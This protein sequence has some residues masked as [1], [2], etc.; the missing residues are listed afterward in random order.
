[1]RALGLGVVAYLLAAPF[2]A[3]GHQLLILAIAWTLNA[4]AYTAGAS[5]LPRLLPLDPIYT[6]AALLTIGSI[7]PRGLAVAAPI[8]GMLDRLLPVL[9]EPAS[10]VAPGAWASAVV[11]PGV[12]VIS[13]WASLLLADAVLVL[14]AAF[15]I[16]RG[17]NGRLWLAVL[18]AVL[19]GHHALTAVVISPPDLRD[20]EAAGIPF[21]IAMLVSGDVQ[22]G[23]RLAERLAEMSPA[24][25]APLLG[26]GLLLATY[27]LA[28]GLWLLT[29]LLLAIVRAYQKR[30][31]R[32][33]RAVIEM[34]AA[35]VM[36]DGSI[37][38][39]SGG[40]AV[41]L[42]ERAA[43]VMTGGSAS[44]VS[45]AAMR[46]GVPRRVLAARLGVV[47]L[48]ALV[49]VTPLDDLMAARAHFLSAQPGGVGGAGGSAERD[50]DERSQLVAAA[51]A[52]IQI[53]AVVPSAGPSVVSVHG[54]RFHYTYLVN[55]IP[56]T[57]KGI[58]YNVRYRSLS[59]EAR[60]RR[61]DHDF[62]ILKRS[63]VN[64]IFGWEPREFDRVL[65]DAAA[66]H[67]LGVA[68]PFELDPDADY[69]DPLV[70][71]RLT[72][73]V[74][75]WVR[76]YKDHPAIRMWAIGNE[77]LHKLV[78]PSWM[79]LQSRP[80]WERQAVAFTRFYVQLVDRV[81]L[82]DPNHPIVHRDAEDAYI[83]WLRDGFNDGV[84]RPWFIYGINAYTPRLAQ[85]LTDWP[86]H[87]FDVAL[88]ISEFA[89][90]GVSPVDR[91]RGYSAMWRVIEAAHGRTLG[92]AIYAWTTAG[93]EEVDRVF[94]LVD[95]KG[96]PVDGS[97]AAV[98][99]MYLGLPD[100]PRDD[101]ETV[102]TSNTRVH[103]E[104]L[105]VIEL[106]Q[107]DRLYEIMSVDD[108][109]SVMGNLKDVPKR[110]VQDGELE[111]VRV[112]DSQ[113]R[114]W[115]KTIGIVDEWWV[116]WKPSTQAHRKLSFLMREY[117]SG[118]LRAS[119]VYQGPR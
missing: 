39:M 60:I 44:G 103:D 22:G 55:G 29:R 93:P 34:S 61:L 77:V 90:G 74:L 57:I 48:A 70:R 25:R 46:A 50:A 95:A 36:T 101:V 41:L 58:G 24:V 94:G 42:P 18:G 38:L 75:D 21:A 112:T 69:G 98:Q 5:G 15:L 84:P 110:A 11:D 100:A 72:S 28:A 89:P 106:I 114:A 73:D 2:V 113:R 117:T 8:G 3:I 62:A 33:L 71:Q 115:Q 86:A 66:R 45:S 14:V 30:R 32:S 4:V 49:V 16:R 97:F 27:A 104:A 47:G 19:L 118:T 107:Q 80:E 53:D 6:S 35:P 7:Q 13:R 10:L 83:S 96:Q 105:R 76:R 108:A 111:I 119:Y 81:H 1:M 56:R 63:G 116:T 31:Q 79:P 91:P 92:G 37:A 67:G 87:R 59:D 64:T 82:E 20:V 12:T 68:P 54:E 99:A 109:S 17:L 102:P 40:A 65:L 23:P 85:I 9:F 88:M 26:L 51:A 52:P 43:V 78:Y